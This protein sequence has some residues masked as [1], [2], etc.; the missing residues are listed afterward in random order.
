MSP[1]DS[2]RRGKEFPKDSDRRGKEFPKDS[3]R[4]GRRKGNTIK[5]KTKE[6]GPS[7]IP[8]SLPIR[9]PEQ[10]RPSITH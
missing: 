7:S 4:R 10:H 6:E 2:D 5:G 1:K 8:L 3:D 9:R